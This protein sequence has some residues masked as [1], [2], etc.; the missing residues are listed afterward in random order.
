MIRN[1]LDVKVSPEMARFISNRLGD[2]EI[3][4]AVTLASL[5]RFL[6]TW[7][8][9]AFMESESLHHIDDGNSLVDELDDLIEQFG[10]EANAADFLATEASEALSRVIEASMEEMENPPTLHD[11]KVAMSSGLAARLVARGGLEEDEDETLVQEIGELIGRFGE[12]AL[13]E[14][15]IRYE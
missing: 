8:P 13:A 3:E 6:S 15:F 12:D 5:R 4:E 1:P 14:R 11:V 2:P 9:E 7:L 10:E